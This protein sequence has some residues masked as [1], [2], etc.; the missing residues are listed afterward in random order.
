MEQATKESSN[1]HFGDEESKNR[2]MHM[3]QI[4]ITIAATQVS[5]FLDTGASCSLIDN[6]VSKCIQKCIEMHER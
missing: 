5:T 2:D 4:P 1:A 3:T 6:N